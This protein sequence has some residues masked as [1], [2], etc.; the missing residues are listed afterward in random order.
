[1]KYSCAFMYFKTPMQ[2]NALYAT[3]LLLLQY[4]MQ[5]RNAC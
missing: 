2:F 1:M 4:N 3:Y 5:A